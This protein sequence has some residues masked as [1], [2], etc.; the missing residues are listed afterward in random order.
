MSPQSK[1]QQILIVM[2]KV[3]ASIIKDTTPEP[4]TRH[5]LHCVRRAY[6]V[7]LTAR[8]RRATI[9]LRRQGR[10]LRIPRITSA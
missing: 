9:R 3:L 7:C 1:E 8:I 6:A 4:G 10:S 5:A 2:R